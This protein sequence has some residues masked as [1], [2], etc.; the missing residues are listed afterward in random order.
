MNKKGLGETAAPYEGL[1]QKTPGVCGG[2][3]CIRG[4]RIPVWQLVEH[5]QYGRTDDTLLEFFPD[6]TREDLAA[7]WAYYDAHEA[8]IEAEI[9]ENDFDDV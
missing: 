6:L 7:A 4:M 2:A 1:I 5:R 9:A 8:E 3:A